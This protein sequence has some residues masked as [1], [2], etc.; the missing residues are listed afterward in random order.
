[1]KL[2]HS[3]AALAFALTL[4]ACTTS[5]VALVQPPAASGTVLAPAPA[6]ASPPPAPAAVT[7]AP[8]LPP[9]VVEPPPAVPSL[10]PA[11]PVSSLLESVQAAVAAGDFERGAAISE[12][13]LRISPRDARLWYQLAVIRYRQSRFD[14]AANTARRALALAAGDSELQRQINALL[15]QVSR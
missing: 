4:T 15:E 14:E 8:Q 11:T 3:V 12:R 2:Q 5:V 10:P 1:M 7:P 9:P 13:A 6:T